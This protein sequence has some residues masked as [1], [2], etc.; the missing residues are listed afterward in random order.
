M[1]PTLALDDKIAVDKLSIRWRPP[2]RGEIVAFDFGGRT[3]VKRVV[4]V[5]GDEVAVRNGV[6][7][8][9]GTSVVRRPI[10]PTRYRNRDESS[11]RISYEDVL[12][13]EE[14]HG[15]RVYR[16]YGNRSGESTMHDYPRE[17]LGGVGCD[18]QTSMGDRDLG[19]V[20]LMPTAG[21]ACKLPPH[22]L[23]LMGDNRDNS[24]DSR[25]WGA[26]PTVFVF[27]RVVGIWLGGEGHR[28]GHIGG[29]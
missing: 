17:E 26:L 13:Y 22:T 29:V 15:G 3:F 21:G 6:L 7:F 18:A 16:T 9:N 10:G 19:T 2:E 14:R 11:G 25:V 23:F 12:E 28:L 27:G 4:A 24:N 1:A 5:G 20:S 8:V